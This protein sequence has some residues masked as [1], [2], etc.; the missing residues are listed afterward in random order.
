[1]HFV[2]VTLLYKYYDMRTGN[3]TDGMYLFLIICTLVLSFWIGDL[4]RKKILSH[5]VLESYWSQNLSAA[6]GI[7]VEIIIIITG[8]SAGFLLIRLV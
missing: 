4:L 6:V 3:T 8:V 2:G 5:L 1:V 7:L